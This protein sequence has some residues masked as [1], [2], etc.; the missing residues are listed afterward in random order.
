[1]NPSPCLLHFLEAAAIFWLMTPFY[2]SKAT[3][4]ILSDHPFDATSPF[5]SDLKKLP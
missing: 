2:I 4:L 5:V 1:M 3:Q